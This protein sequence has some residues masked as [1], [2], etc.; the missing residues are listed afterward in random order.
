MVCPSP[1]Q[2]CVELAR[3]LLHLQD[4]YDLPSF[5]RLRHAALVSLTVHQPLLLAP[6]L[7]SEFYGPHHSTRQRMDIL[8]VCVVACVGS[9]A[10]LATPTASLFRCSLL[11]PV[12]SPSHPPSSLTQHLSPLTHPLPL[13]HNHKQKH[14]N[15]L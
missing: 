12:N 9:L 3:V 11:Q 8:E 10:C 15:R 13:L 7:T 5:A 14:G 4:S 6:Y 2:V 1:V